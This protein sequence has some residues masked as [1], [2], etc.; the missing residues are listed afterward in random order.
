M[1]SWS[2]ETLTF[3]PNDTVGQQEWERKENLYK[4]VWLFQF[5]TIQTLLILKL[6]INNFFIQI[7]LDSKEF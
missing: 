3:T 4:D 2:K 5:S 6:N 1:L 7:S